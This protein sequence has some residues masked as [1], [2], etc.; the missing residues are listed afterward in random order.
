MIYA[1]QA[2]RT[3][4]QDDASVLAT[5]ALLLCIQSACLVMCVLGSAA[6]AAVHCQ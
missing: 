3:H 5:T 1:E 6:A 2:R 4:G